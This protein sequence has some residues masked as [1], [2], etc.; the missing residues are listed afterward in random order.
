MHNPPISSGANTSY[1]LVMDESP[2]LRISENYRFVAEANLQNHRNNK[3]W[4]VA[5]VIAII[6]L[7]AFSVLMAHVYGYI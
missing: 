6:V 4:A 5:A 3:L 1:Q 2:D 7:M